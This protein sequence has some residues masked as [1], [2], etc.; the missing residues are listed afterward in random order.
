MLV[1]RN[2]MTKGE[3]QNVVEILLNLPSGE[4]NKL[5]TDTLIKMHNNI[6]VNLLSYNI[7]EDKVRE[8]QN[9]LAKAPLARAK[10][11]SYNKSYNK[12]DK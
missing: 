8:L 6:N 7:L 9:L 4:L 3:L 2:D 10:P 11:R 1:L 12:R 5:H